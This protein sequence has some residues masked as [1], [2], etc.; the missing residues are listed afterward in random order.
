MNKE[1][2]DILLR[3]NVDII[4]DA[5]HEELLIADN[6]GV[7]LKV[8]PTFEQV[9]GISIEEATG[10]TVFQ[11]EE[12]G[13]FAPSIVALVLRRKSEVTM[14]QKTRRGEDILVTAIPIFDE[15]KNIK[16]V[17]SFSRDITEITRLQARFCQLNNKVEKYEREIQRL[18]KK[19]NG[20]QKI[21]S[22]SPEMEEIMATI[23]QVADFD[24]NVLLLGASGVGKTMLA[25]E[26]HKRSRRCCGPFVDI[27]C[28]AIPDTL[29]ESELF[30]YE[31]GAFTGA[32]KGGKKGLVEMAEGGTLLLDEI[33]EMPMTLQAKLL[34]TIQDKEIVRVGGTKTVAV[35]F[36][37]LTAT[38]KD[39]EQ[40]VDEGSFRRD[41]YY[42]LNVVSL[43]IPTL[44]ERQKDI[45]P[46][47]QFFLKEFN[48]RYD[49][50]KEFHPNALEAFMEY[51]W[52]GNVRQLA[53]VIERV[54]VTT[55]E[56][57]LTCQMLP[58]SLTCSEKSKKDV[59]GDLT[60]ALEAFEGEIIRGA[61]EKYKSSTEVGKAL[62]ISQP[63]A[64]R[65]IKK[66]V[67][68]EVIQR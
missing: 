59:E 16:F 18:R 24:V 25:R 1:E 54:A 12:A 41:L 34:K 10:S 55:N 29:L 48:E 6:Q 11:L 52:P 32:G 26:I 60:L 36:R 61:Y 22:E 2:V 42:R 17:V 56:N 65:K 44:K 43:N 7:V 33:S 20:E 31:E 67:D 50:E 14:P 27:N 66:Y 35:D 62:N 63:T 57:V 49:K 38:N 4:L 64:Y 40:M 68:G 51:H 5:M 45:V 47:S 53:N 15:E 46:L 58:P 8:N 21:L 23:N 9:Y 3:E 30:G 28:A 39:L 13:Y 37:L 19:A